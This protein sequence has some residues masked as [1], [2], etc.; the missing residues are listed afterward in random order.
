MK[1]K[2]ELVR[3]IDLES[4]PVMFGSERK[5][6]NRVIVV[7]S[8][9]D[10]DLIFKGQWKVNVEFVRDIDLES[11]PIRFESEKIEKNSGYRGNEHI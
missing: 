9:F 5:E 11:V 2:V 6:R 4:V 8:Q 10:L 3:D 7:T 1:V